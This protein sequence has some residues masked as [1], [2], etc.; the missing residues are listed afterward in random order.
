VFGAV[1]EP[2][3]TRADLLVVVVRPDVVLDGLPPG[4]V[5]A[6]IGPDE[7]RGARL[8]V[9]LALPPAGTPRVC[10]TARGLPA[11]Q[12]FGVYRTIENPPGGVAEVAADAC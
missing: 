8:A 12:G 11:S 4:A 3:D 6:L 1:L 5:R 10:A 2:F 7:P 9:W